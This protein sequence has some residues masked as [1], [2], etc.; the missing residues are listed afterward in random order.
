MI[1]RQMV[2]ILLGEFRNFPLSLFER[3]DFQ[4]T[5]RVQ[6]KKIGDGTRDDF[7]PMRGQIEIADA[8]RLDLAAHAKF[9]DGHLGIEVC[10]KHAVGGVRVVH[11]EDVDGDGSAL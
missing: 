2:R 6:G 4:I 5:L 9:L 1:I 3:A 11:L 10:R 8:A 7:Q